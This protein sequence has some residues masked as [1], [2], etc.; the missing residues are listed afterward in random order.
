MASTEYHKQ[1][2][3]IRKIVIGDQYKADALKTIQNAVQGN[4]YNPEDVSIVNFEGEIIQFQA[5]TVVTVFTDIAKKV[6]PG[7]LT[8]AVLKESELAV[9]DAIEKDY[10]SLALDR[11]AIRKTAEALLDR[12]DKGFAADNQFIDLK[13]WQKDY[14][15]HEPCQ[16]CRA[17]GSVRCQ[18]CAG[19]GTE[20]CPRCNGTGRRVCHFCN[21]SQMVLGPNQQNVQCT[22]CHGTGKSPCDLCAQKRTIQCK[23]CAAKGITACPNCH[24]SAWSS[25]LYIC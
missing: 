17:T 10:N 14:V 13:F 7:R 18:K 19:K 12:D 20:F 22:T 16:T 24:G 5:E 4:Q 11:N 8:E 6:V 15:V 25:H 21:G 23:T 1:D 9:K 3:E 2:L